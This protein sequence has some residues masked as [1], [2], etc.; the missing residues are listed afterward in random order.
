MIKRKTSYYD[1][2]ILS[3]RSVGSNSID[4]LE[5]TKLIPFFIHRKMSWL[6]GIY[7]FDDLMGEGHIALIK[8]KRAFDETKG[9]KFT[10]FAMK[11]FFQSFTDFHRKEVKVRGLYDYKVL[12]KR[13]QKTDIR[14]VDESDF[15]FSC[16]PVK[17]YQ[18]R[19]KYK[20][21]IN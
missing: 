6:I 4:I 16:T 19:N 1:L 15:L 13:K 9:L 5:Y 10:T 18:I 14:S 2:S 21:G 7:D 17:A 11:V 3:H 12:V 20:I 8:A